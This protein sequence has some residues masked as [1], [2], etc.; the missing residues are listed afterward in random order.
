MG[1]PESNCATGPGQLRG[2][3]LVIGNA[4]SALMNSGMDLHGALDLVSNPLEG[5]HAACVHDYRGVAVVTQGLLYRLR[6]IVDALRKTYEGRIV[7]LCQMV[8]EPLIRHFIQGERDHQTTWTQDDYLICPAS[9]VRLVSL[10]VAAPDKSESDSL[11]PEGGAA[12]DQRMR[13]LEQLATED[14]LTGLKNRRYVWEFGR[15]ILDY[16]REETARVTLLVYDIDDFKHYNDVYG[17]PA[18]DK[19]LKEAAVLMRRCCRAH[20]VVGRIGGDEFV[21]IFWDDPRVNKP[22]TETE[23]RSA[24]MEHPQEAIFVARRFQKELEKSELRFLGPEG[25][26]VLTISGG[27]ATYPRDG[28]TVERLFQKADDAL[29]EA[30][31][32]GKN[33][34]YLVG[35]PQGEITVTEAQGK[36]S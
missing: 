20:D 22:R 9:A 26:G 31:R 3:I 18:G 2:K 15:Q 36:E 17:H 34:I 4:H 10:F 1:M 19:I 29:L 14:D 27:L 6:S 23:R 32:S 28:Q 35:T 16:A 12:Y 13:L 11:R 8:E 33:R 30:K 25:K 7:L 5:I 21:V 24:Q